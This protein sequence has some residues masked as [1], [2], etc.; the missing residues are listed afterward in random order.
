MTDTAVPSAKPVKRR[1]DQD[2][3]IADQIA[4]D[5]QYLETVKTDAEI[6]EILA[7]RGYDAAKLDDGLALQREAQAAFTRRQVAMAAQSRATAGLSGNT[8]TARE[9]YVDF[10]ETVRAITDFT[11][12]DRAALKVTGVVSPD[13]QKMITAARASY[14]VAQAEPFASILATYGYPPAAIA[15]A[16]AALDAYAAADTDQNSAIGSATKATA[17]RNAAVTALDVYMKQLRGIAKVALRKRPDL[18]K[19]LN[20]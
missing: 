8:A 5:G 3:K 20:G 4:A 18:L 15:A 9:M 13:K 6:L 11:A 7:V 1:A 17:D 14:Q 16:L 10:R 2:Q 19:K 12:S